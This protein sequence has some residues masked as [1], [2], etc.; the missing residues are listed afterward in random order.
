MTSMM[1]LPMSLEKIISTEI[2]GFGLEGESLLTFTRLT[3]EALLA[4]GA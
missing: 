1:F 3:L 4:Q 2:D